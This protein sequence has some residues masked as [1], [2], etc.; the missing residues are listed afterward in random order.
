MPEEKN[1]QW[2]FD[3]ELGIVRCWTREIMTWLIQI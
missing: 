1:C 3:Y 2:V